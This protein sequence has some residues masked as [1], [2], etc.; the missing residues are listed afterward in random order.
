MRRS[1]LFRNNNH[2]VHVHVHVHAQ[3]GSQ[4]E[5]HKANLTPIVLLA[6]ESWV[7]LKPGLK[8]STQSVAYRKETGSADEDVVIVA[9]FNDYGKTR[10]RIPN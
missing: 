10:L 7:G 8:F 3:V 4:G 6:S 2:F 1:N 5:N 9:V